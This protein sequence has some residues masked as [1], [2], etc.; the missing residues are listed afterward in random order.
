MEIHLGL[1]CSDTNCLVGAPGEYH[2]RPTGKKLAHTH[3][4]WLEMALGVKTSSS[5][6]EVR[7]QSSLWTSHHLEIEHD[8]HPIEFRHVRRR[9]SSL[10]ESKII[11][12]PNKRTQ[13]P[14]TPGLPDLSRSTMYDYA[15][16]RLKMRRVSPPTD[17]R[18]HF[19]Q[20]YRETAKAHSRQSL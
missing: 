16:Y 15:H 14:W 10:H 13:R 20:Q 2:E 19:L 7:S 12:T 11:S 18:N 6:R 9:L 5:K 4:S 8:Q 3:D 1:F 17:G